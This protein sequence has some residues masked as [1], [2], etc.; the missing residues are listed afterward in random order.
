MGERAACGV[1]KPDELPRAFAQFFACPSDPVTT[2]TTTSSDA[3]DPNQ[4][5]PPPPPP[6]HAHN[7]LRTLYALS[8]TV[9]L[10]HALLTRLEI[11]FIGASLLIIYQ[12]DPTGLAHAWDAVDR[13]LASGDGLDAVE[14][15]S[16]DDDEDGVPS[17]DDEEESTRGGGKNRTRSFFRGIFHQFG[18]ERN[19]GS[20]GFG[21]LDG[22]PP[23]SPHTSRPS[24]PTATN[25]APPFTFRLIDFA[26]T[27]LADGQGPDEGVLKG[28]ETVLGLVRGRI[29]Q[30]EGGV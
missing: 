15:A 9:S 4:A 8:S 1:L 13:G 21:L 20:Q 25:P 6:T 7:L 2:T 3:S 11:R 27:R 16:A 23:S 18:A 12:G 30:L 26:H 5:P 19:D 17:D 28:L 14:P 10:L 24:S 22:S 29:A